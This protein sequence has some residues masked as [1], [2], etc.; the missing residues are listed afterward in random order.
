MPRILLPDP[1]L[2]DGVVTLR[3]PTESDAEAVYEYCQDPEIGR[4]TVIPDPY[5]LEDART[6]IASAGNGPAAGD[7][8]GFVI[9]SASD[10]SPLGSC[11]LTRIHWEDLRAEIGYVVAASARRKGL[12][13]RALR[14]LSRWALEELGLERVEAPVHP[15]NEPSQR[16]ARAAGFTEEGLFRSYRERKG[17]RED[18][19]IFSLIKSD[20]DHRQRR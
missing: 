8:V 17:R 6:W 2:T 10:D 5:S 1:P 20:L 16:L 9:A 15:R 11:G 7:E 12:G 14:L 3:P 4:W 13:T 19:L 18:Y